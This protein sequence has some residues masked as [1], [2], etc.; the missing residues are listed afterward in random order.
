M[1]AL[2][3]QVVRA[4]TFGHVDLDAI[5]AGRADFAA[6]RARYAAAQARLDEVLP[7]FLIGPGHAETGSR[8]TNLADLSLARWDDP[9]VWGDREV[10]GVI[11]LAPS[12]HAIEREV[13]PRGSILR[14]NR[15]FDDYW[16]TYC[17]GGIFTDLLVEDG[18][19]AGGSVAYGDY[20]NTSWAYGVPRR[21]LAAALTVPIDHPA[22]NDTVAAR[23]LYDRV[24]EILR[25][26]GTP[27]AWPPTS[28]YRG[29]AIEPISI[30]SD[31]DAIGIG[32][33]DG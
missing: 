25:E 32:R 27:T 20:A 4:V 17:Y 24:T 31:L 28:P 15:W 11:D 12:V 9:D 13:L 30:P 22:A 33:R 29:N 19:L 21:T 8:W 6:G 7:A 18:L 3:T 10:N 23:A 14:L 1:G 16:P 5:A 2:R 26:I